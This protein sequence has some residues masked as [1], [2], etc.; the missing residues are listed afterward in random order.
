LRAK[1]SN[2]FFMRIEILNTGSELMLGRV[3]NSHQQWLCRQL[4]DLGY[5][6]ERQVAVDDSGAAIEQAVAEA[7]ARAELVIVTGG[8][9]PTSDDRTR[10]RIAVLLGRPLHEDAAVLASIEG[11]FA[12]RRRPMPRSTR[13]QAMVPEGALVLPNR[14]GTA[15]GLVMDTSKSTI[16]GSARSHSTL[17]VMLPGPPRELHPMFLEQVVPLLKRSFPLPETFVCRTLKTTGLGESMVEERIAGPLALLT[18]SGL[19][20]GILRAVG[21]S[22]FTFGGQRPFRQRASVR[23]RA[24]CALRARR[25]GLRSR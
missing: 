19:E 5:P 15:P 9:G 20:L 16:D 4:A 10:D 13:V 25:T 3:L 22:R 23:S 7:L 14:H 24:H 17:L 2:L 1:L 11:M 21:R 18:T 6:V 12:A 8:L